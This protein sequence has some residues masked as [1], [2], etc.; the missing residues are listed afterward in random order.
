MTKKCDRHDQS[1]F[2]NSKPGMH[3]SGSMSFRDF[4]G[5]EDKYN[6]QS[7]SEMR[8]LREEY[9]E[10]LSAKEDEHDY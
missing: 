6:V 7:K 8:S 10:Y 5:P 3:R 2:P 1:Q 9:H 4:C